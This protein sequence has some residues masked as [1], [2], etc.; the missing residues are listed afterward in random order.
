MGRSRSVGRA[1]YG[2]EL[3]CICCSFFCQILYLNLVVAVLQNPELLLFIEQIQASAT[4]ELEE[5]D[6]DGELAGRFAKFVDNQPVQPI[7]GEGF[8]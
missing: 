7:H 6:N 1:H 2:Q 4:I 5:A 3:L 8:P